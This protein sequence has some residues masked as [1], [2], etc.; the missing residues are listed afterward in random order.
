MPSMA[1]CNLLRRPTTLSSGD[2]RG[3]PNSFISY[4]LQ[5]YMSRPVRIRTVSD[6]TP[7]QAE[8]PCRGSAGGRDISGAPPPTVHCDRPELCA[9]RGRYRLHLHLSRRTSLQQ[10]SLTLQCQVS[11]FQSAAAQH[12]QIS[13]N[14]IA[15]PRAFMLCRHRIP[16]RS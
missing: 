2:C 12:L 10:W 4:I 13:E 1:W 8:T 7:G 11:I 14:K 9:R 15:V 3:R 5:R 16:I 6:N